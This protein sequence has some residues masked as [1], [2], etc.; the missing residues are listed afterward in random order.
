MEFSP[1][2]KPCYAFGYFP[3]TKHKQM[4]V[5]NTKLGCGSYGEDYDTAIIGYKKL[6]D[7]YEEND[8]GRIW[9]AFPAYKSIIGE[10]S[11]YF[12]TRRRVELA[13]TTICHS[14]IAKKD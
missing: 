2:G 13:S 6:V 9:S 12:V 14:I 3:D 4:E 5:L 11:V 8:F 7:F 10:N 1:I